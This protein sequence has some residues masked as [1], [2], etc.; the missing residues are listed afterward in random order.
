MEVSALSYRTILK[1]KY[2]LFVPLL[3]LLLVAMACGEEEAEP[4][5]AP[6]AYHGS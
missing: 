5:A 2:V 4:T 3:V 6:E 1:G